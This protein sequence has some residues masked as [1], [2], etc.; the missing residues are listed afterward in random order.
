MFFLDY[1]CFFVYLAPNSNSNNY[2]GIKAPNS[3]TYIKHLGY[4]D[5]TAIAIG[6]EEDI[7]PLENI[8]NTFE[9]A[10]GNQIKPAKS[11]IMWLGDWPDP[12]KEI[13]GT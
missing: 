12:N 10:S 3:D 5:D 9:K 4:A 2:K 1:S 11:Y 8:L 6:S 13:Y 7:A